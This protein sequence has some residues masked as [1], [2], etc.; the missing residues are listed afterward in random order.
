MDSST[1]LTSVNKRQYSL[2]RDDTKSKKDQYKVWKE[3]FPHIKDI[4]ISILKQI[5]VVIIGL[6]YFISIIHLTNNFMIAVIFL[7]LF[8]MCFIIIFRNDIF[9]FQSELLN[10]SEPPLKNYEFW[11]FSYD[12]SIIFM[13]SHQE[14]ITMGI[15][16][17]QI[18]VLPENVKANLDRFISA[19][20][21]SFIPF[22]YQIIQKP[23]LSSI[24]SKIKSD[25]KNRFETI[26]Y[27]SLFSDFRGRFTI[28]KVNKLIHKLNQYSLS[29]NNNFLAN[30]HHY[31]IISLKG[32]ELKSALRTF[33]LKKKLYN[34]EGSHV[35][36]GQEINQFIQEPNDYNFLKQKLS[37]YLSL[38]LVF[39]S[40]ILISLDLLLFLSQIFFIYR[41][42]T[43]LVI[44]LLLIYYWI[45]QVL[46][47]AHSPNLANQDSLSIQKIDIFDGVNFFKIPGIKETLFYQTEDGYLGGIKQLN[48]SFANPPIIAL[49][50]KYYQAIIQQG[51]NFVYTFQAS[52][53]SYEQFTN[54]F[55]KF[56]SDKEK[57]HMQYKLNNSVKQS[58]WLGQRR[59]IWRTILTLSTSVSIFS[60]QASIQN[61]EKI[62]EELQNNILILQNAFSSN[63]SNCHFTSLHSKVLEMGIIFETLKNN[64]FRNNGTHL[65]YL[66]FQGNLLASL[67]WLSDLF[68]K[69]I[70]TK[71]A[72]E[73]NSPLYLENFINIGK[74]INTETLTKEVYAGFT[75][76]QL[77][78]LLIMNGKL[79][80]QQ[81]LSM[82]IVC[83]LIKKSYHSVIFDFTGEWTRL[84]HLFEGSDFENNFLYYKIG[85]TFNLDLVHSGILYDP[86]NVDYLDY[87][88]EAY[89]NCFKKDDRTIEAFKNTIMNSLDRGNEISTST[90][91]LDI[92]S[93]PDWKH[94]QQKEAIDSVLNF[95]HDF[96]REEMNF[97]HMR[98]VSSNSQ[99]IIQEFLSAER[100]I[101]IDLSL[102]NGLEKKLFLMFIVLAK[103]I[104][105][106]K[107]GRDFIPKSL[108]LPHIDI[109]FDAFF[110]D[111]NM[112]Y[113]RIDKFFQPLRNAGFGLICLA[114]QARYLHSK[115]FSE[116]ENLITF[117]AT[118][119]RDI[120]TLKSTMGLDYVHG[121]GIYSKNRNESYQ[122]NYLM[123]MRFKEA[124]MKR[125]DIYQPFPI[126]IEWDMQEES[127]K[128]IWADVIAYMRLQGYD[129]EFAEKQLIA[130]TKKTIFEKDFGKYTWF[131][132]IIIAFL[133]D[134]RSM[135]QIGNLFAETI[136]KELKTR[137]DAK[138]SKET[139]NKME[140]KR[141][142]DEIF[143]ILIKYEYLKE[144]HPTQAS[145][146]ESIRTSY[147]VGP[148]FDTALNDY[149][150]VK[151]QIAPEV[152]I[153]QHESNDSNTI[154][155]KIS[156]KKS[157]IEPHKLKRVIASV[158][159]ETL[160][161]NLFEIYK[162]IN[163]KDYRVGLEKAKD[164]L[165]HFIFQLYNEYY[166]VDYVITKNDLEDFIYE[167]T[168]SK[169]FPFNYDEFK[170]YLMLCENISFSDENLEK[171]IQTI[172]D[173][174][175]LIHTKIKNYVY[176]N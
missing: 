59:G 51:I 133:S 127:E 99:N 144:H 118:D 95:I 69:G 2:E 108:I 93:K 120:A 31:K 70:E 124:L 114:S 131:I 30:F 22:S 75:K 162:A 83:E 54:K 77:D 173:Q 86:N 20:A 45:P 159:G 42:L 63:F 64:C 154:F 89:A 113:G 50:Y 28:N 13:T 141:M 10:E 85:K 150:Q 4:P 79:N 142:R 76:A 17:Y 56:L 161:L 155:S 58:N 46:S 73:F 96:T 126:E 62:E 102:S 134:L 8:F 137:L 6:I 27:F 169:D 125:D 67:I 158:F 157:S 37:I 60:S 156:T 168:S 148:K 152:E 49:P 16:L 21:S 166:D 129:L 136:K 74:T 39:A 117:K 98:P 109:I 160:F 55:S 48:L 36:H 107:N 143:Q 172:Y 18:K 174:L 90:V 29:M 146:S 175:D 121:K 41:I 112:R 82:K 9:R 12:R 87:M 57:N 1:N 88:L 34:S 140:K 80:Q 139:Q 145:G 68:K 111:K 170:K 52:P 71:I 38:K 153:I 84:I 5:I 105:Y 104:H 33:I 35:T 176:S 78:N 135:D 164:Y 19:L 53:I 65:N 66:I 24:E 25:A 149:I 3:E 14:Q 110:L 61:L 165:N 44:A 167:I 11:Q 138:F 151:K 40:I 15:K 119:N 7:L 47:F 91:S 94:G 43:S 97:F 26:I 115:L 130:Q 103:F 100:T 81:L 147:Y 171:T 106:I 92:K 101:I 116:F 72:T 23:L 128:M 122:I 163:R 132:D 32:T 123:S